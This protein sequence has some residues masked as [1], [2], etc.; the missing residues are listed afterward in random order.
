MPIESPLQAKIV[1]YLKG[2]GLSQRKAGD[3]LDISESTFGT[4]V[5]MSSAM[6]MDQLDKILTEYPG[7]RDIIIDYLRGNTDQKHTGMDKNGE[8]NGKAADQFYRNLI[9]NNSEYRLVPKKLFDDYDILP[10]KE[11]E[12]RSKVMEVVTKAMEETKSALIDKY[13]AQIVGHK[14]RTAKL[15]SENRKLRE[16]IIRLG[17]KIPPQDHDE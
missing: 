12:S 14:S 11:T 17:G 16:E 13:E 3:K 6:G 15:I 2:L 9:E 5:R 1:A 10:K 7:A 8:I 4:W